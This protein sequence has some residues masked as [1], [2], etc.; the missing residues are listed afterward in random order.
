MKVLIPT[1]GTRGDIQPYI[2]IAKELNKKGFSTIIG[3]HPCWQELVESYNI[4]FAP[5]GP[6]IDIEY[7]SSC[8][9]NNS[10]HWIF[11]VIKTMKFIMKIIENS[12]T[13]IKQLCEDVDLVIASH[14][15]I[16]SA[17][18]EACNLPYISVTLQPDSIPEKLKNK[19][20]FKSIIDR[21]IGAIV[22]PL[23]VR[24]YNKIRK[25]LGLK[26]VKSFDDL[27]S[28]YLNII[29]ISPI[30]YPPNKYWEEKNRLVGYWFLEEE[31]EYQP[32]ELLKNFL[33]SDEPPVI[34]SLGAMGFESEEEK[35]KLKI[36]INSINE[37]GMRAIIQGFNKTL[38]NYSL[39]ENIINIG[40]V[41]HSWLFKYAYCVIHH[42][43]LSTTAT[44]L[45]A[46]VPSIVIPHVLDQNLWAQRV[47]EL[48]VGAEPLKSKEL[49]QEL[50]IE[51]IK[52][53]KE[54][55]KSIFDNVKLISKKI[56]NE[57]GLKKSIELIKEKMS[58]D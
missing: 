45:K 58:N 40:N 27:L 38:K 23:M 46:G 10:K 1:M 33:E 42:G 28:P 50:L 25:K 43:G 2:A 3:S 55:Y 53:I 51:R 56:N 15:H 21:F 24:S 17:E 48:E 41:P 29:P 26:K 34:I 20:F 39:P 37:T 9:R 52:Y 18:A 19:T 13:E 30:V 12:S 8:I 11:G 57:N 31:E 32:P 6:D 7:E 4:I 16:G 22:N 44:V 14:S 36:F 35:N 5:I 49:S 47:F 54:N